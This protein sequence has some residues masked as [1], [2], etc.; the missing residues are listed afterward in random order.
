MRPVEDVARTLDTRLPLVELAALGVAGTALV[1]GL[2]S[3]LWPQ[4]LDVPLGVAEEAAQITLAVG[5]VA[6]LAQLVMGRT[7]VA[8][9]GSLWL[10]GAAGLFLFSLIRSFG[11]G[12]L[13]QWRYDFELTDF[14]TWCLFFMVGVAAERLSRASRARKR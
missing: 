7:S 12:M 8:A 11:M 13:Y 9:V 10:E 14:Q 3:A 4:W 5:L 6:R 2:E 1:G